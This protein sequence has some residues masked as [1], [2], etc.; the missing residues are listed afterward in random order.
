MSSTI[1]SPQPRATNQRTP[2]ARRAGKVLATWLEALLGAALVSAGGSG[3]F[4]VLALANIAT[5]PWVPWS[6]AALA[7]Y[8][9]AYWAWLGGRG[10][11]RSTAAARARNLRARQPT[12]KVR[13]WALAAG[14]LAMA[15]D[16]PV[17]VVLGR[18]LPLG[19]ELPPALLQLPPLT[20]AA[21]L[22]AVAVVAGVVEEA[23]FRGY[24]QSP[25]E[26]RHGPLVAIVVSTLVFTL[27]H[28]GGGRALTP[29]NFA[30]VALAGVNYGVLAWLTGS[31]RPGIVLHTSGDVV[32][33]GLLWWIHASGAI[34]RPPAAGLR[35]ALCEPAVLVQCAAGAI[36][37]VAAVWAY[38]RLARAIRDE[39]AAH[40][41]GVPH[42]IR[43]DSADR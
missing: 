22:L 41:P 14:G 20:T 8:L 37:A 30:L 7:V 3:V 4:S 10:W 12:A 11:P 43:V 27:A 38:V 5:T 28:T 25:L 13:R 16:L 24:L 15:L 40:D 42:G 39:T 9:P 29:A 31:I 19:G 21:L 18:F 17:R 32:G 36:L 35:D 6:V 2:V 1:A 34:G 23:A 26:R 33:L